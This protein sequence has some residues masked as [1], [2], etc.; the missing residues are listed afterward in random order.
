MKGCLGWDVEKFTEA[1][2]RLALGGCGKGDGS[3]IGWRA[4]WEV[5]DSF[6]FSEFPAGAV[7]FNIEIF[8]SI[9]RWFGVN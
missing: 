3:E 6:T 1:E 4:R 2:S 9:S 5:S 8:F 7:F